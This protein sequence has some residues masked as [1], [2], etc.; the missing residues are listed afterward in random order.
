MFKFFGKSGNGERIQRRKTFVLPD[1]QEVVF[2]SNGLVPVIL[3]DVATK[4]VLHLGYMD[5][6]AL[7]ATI[8]RGV[9]Y[10]YRRSKGKLEAFGGNSDEHN[11]YLVKQ[12]KMDKMHRSLLFYVTPQNTAQ[13]ETTGNSSFIKD[14]K[15]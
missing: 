11:T 8:E 14:I 5:Q 15:F 7:R 9:V 6:L 10:L 4:E 1:Q 12:A 3:Q 13:V 2:N